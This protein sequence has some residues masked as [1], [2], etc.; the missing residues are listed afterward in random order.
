MRYRRGGSIRSSGDGSVMELE[1]RNR[2]IEPLLAANS[3]E[4]E[5]SITAK[6]FD[7]SKRLVWKAW[8]L[9]R[10]NRGAAGVDE[11]SLD[12]FERDLKNNLYRLWNR[13]TSGSYFPLPVREGLIPK[14]S[15]GQRPLGIP[16]I[17]DRVAQM[18]AKLVLEPELE[19]RFHED[20]YGYRPGKSAH[21][22]IVVTR[23]RCWWHDWVLEFDIR[24]LFDNIDHALLMKA[25]RHHTTSKWLLLYIERWL[26]A[27]VQQADGTL[28]SRTKGT[29][30][31]GVISPLLAN[32][33][34][35][36]AFDRWMTKQ[37][38]RLPFCRYADDGLIHCRSLQQAEYVKER[39]A[40]RL[41]ECVLEIHPDKTRIVYC[42]GVHRYGEYEHIQ[43]DFLGYTFRPR[44]SYDKHGRVFTNFTPAIARSAATALRQEVRSWRLQLKSDKSLEDLSRM[45]SPAIAGWVNY[46][47]RFYASAFNA[48]AKH[49]N[50]ALARWAMRKF[51][52]L[53]GH[54]TRAVKWIEHVAQQR[55]ALF[56][57][58]RAGY[59]FAAR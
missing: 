26:T 35:H 55:P 17:S 19:P 15:G 50:R 53:R 1:R 47:T 56:A 33:F 43:F 5:R 21:Q 36:Y 28:R 8:R 45:F 23:K 59:Q 24:G 7:I 52:K 57:H 30:Q 34:L 54:K 2:V 31:G 27:P 9:V 20:S 32:L 13:M 11:E 10:A 38:P 18:V 29:P 6:P 46:Y 44:R 22:A 4:E 16:T 48:V 37:F 42:K 41:K 40:Q 58:W 39:L 14:K 3:L 49:I 25:I 12:E 51:K